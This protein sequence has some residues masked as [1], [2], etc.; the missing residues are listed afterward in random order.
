MSRTVTLRR[1]GAAVCLAAVVMGAIAC[2]RSAGPGGEANGT[3][4]V[5]GFQAYR[6]CLARNGVTLPSFGPGD[7][8]FPGSG[9]PPSGFPSGRPG[10]G[11]FGGLGGQPPEG[12]DQATWEKAMQ[13]CAS[14]RPSGGPG[15]GFDNAAFTAYRNCLADHGVTVSAGPNQLSTAD[16]K[17]AAAMAVC[18]PLRPTGRPRSPSATP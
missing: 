6:E 17:V 5:N 12:V 18:A 16:P 8:G 15:G 7:G 4:A 13:T 9:P 2:G 11:G 14:V 1:A 3:P 10:P